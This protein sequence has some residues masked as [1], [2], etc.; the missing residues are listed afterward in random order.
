MQSG[1][2]DPPDL[3]DAR[4][5]LIGAGHY[6]TGCRWCHGA[7]GHA[8]SPVLRAAT[9]RP[10]E[11][12][13]IAEVYEASELFFIVRHGVK[14]TGMPGWSA[15]NRDDEVWAVV[16]F[17][18]ALPKL[19]R[20]KYRTL[21]FGDD[22]EHEDSQAPSLVLRRCARCHG[23]RGNGRGLGAFP[24]LAGQN[25]GYL[26]KSLEAYRRGE[27][28]SGIMQPLASDLSKREIERVAAWYS[29]QTVTKAEAG[30]ATSQ[31]G[32]AIAN[33]GIPE[34][35]VPPC[36]DC[37]GPTELSVHDSYPKLRG[38]SAF[39]VEQQLDLF[40]RQ[41]RGGSRQ[42]S[43]MKS[44]QVHALRAQEVRAVALYYGTLS[45]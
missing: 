18:K 33:R 19:D 28:A 23:A 6:E 13:N 3:D 26:E 25:R 2:P 34:R 39:Y 24:R 8:Q 15:A 16:A 37:H 14:F 42:A 12:G 40:A 44:A 5:V 20:S 36:A 21:V 30:S 45:W 32:H 1:T 10:P 17:L 41:V 4:L 7:P 9:P 38:Q 22:L 11:L 43:L 35:R 27:R 29:E 31:V